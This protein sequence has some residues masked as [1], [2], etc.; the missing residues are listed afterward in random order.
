[1]DLPSVHRLPDLP[2]QRYYHSQLGLIACGGGDSSTTRSSYVTFTNVQWVE[3][4]KLL[5]DRY[6]HSSWSSRDYGTII[7]GGS[8]F[9]NWLTCLTI[10][11]WPHQLLTCWH[12]R[13]IHDLQWLLPLIDGKVLHVGRL[14][15]G[16]WSSLNWSRGSSQRQHPQMV[17]H[18]EVIHQRR[19]CSRTGEVADLML[20][21][22]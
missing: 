8:R 3:S 11:R 21:V 16:R 22:T 7:L 5:V 17:V 13:R 6:H 10:A 2:V 12:G 9:V 20:D 1:M 4:N 14:W 19:L 15:R 18:S